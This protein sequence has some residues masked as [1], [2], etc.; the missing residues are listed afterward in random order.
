MGAQIPIIILSYSKFEELA[1]P[2]YHQGKKSLKIR[3][4]KTQ[5]R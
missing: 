2:H 5:N 3:S 1:S 4:L